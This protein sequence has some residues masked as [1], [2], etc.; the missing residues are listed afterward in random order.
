MRLGNLVEHL[1]VQGLL[2][3]VVPAQREE[4]RDD[5]GVLVA[6]RHDVLHPLGQPRV[7]LH[8][9]SS[10]GR[11][12]QSLDLLHMLDVEV[13][14]S[15]VPNQALLFQGRET[16]PSVGAV[17]CLLGVATQLHFLVLAE[18]VLQQDCR[19]DLGGRMQKH[20]V[21]VV[22]TEL[23]DHAAAFFYRGVVAKGVRPDLGRQEDLLA[24][25]A[26]RHGVPDGETDG[27]MVHI[28]GGRVPAALQQ[29][30]E[31]G[32]VDGR[33]VVRR[34]PAAHADPVRRHPGASRQVEEHLALGTRR[35]PQV[36]GHGLGAR[37]PDALYLEDGH[38]EIRKRVLLGTEPSDQHGQEQDHDDAE[39]AATAERGHAVKC[40]MPSSIA[41]C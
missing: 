3:V 4:A 13:A 23:L 30:P 29:V 27:R 40:G 14:D 19:I 28:H 20:E 5:D 25:H 6:I 9:V 11:K 32:S 10:N 37:L 7:V 33:G 22:N 24:G 36:I 2:L 34:G 21:D 15:E 35:G 8:L 17:L 1:D 26:A 31:H 16:S 39:L 41:R 38:D 12:P 18:V